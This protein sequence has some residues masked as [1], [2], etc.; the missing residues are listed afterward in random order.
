[1]GQVLADSTWYYDEYS[2]TIVYNVEGSRSNFSR[3]NRSAEEAVTPAQSWYYDDDS[4]IAYI[5][6]G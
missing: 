5:E 4:G 3:A 1:S 6:V 2:D